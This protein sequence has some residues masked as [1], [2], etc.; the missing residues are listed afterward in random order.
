MY[1]TISTVSEEGFFGTVGGVVE[2]NCQGGR[3]V[4]IKLVLYSSLEQNIVVMVPGCHWRQKT[5]YANHQN[6]KMSIFILSS[7][8]PPGGPGSIQRV[9]GLPERTC[10]FQ[11]QFPGQ[12]TERER[13]FRYLTANAIWN[14][15]Y[16]SHCFRFTKGCAYIVGTSLKWVPN[17]VLP[18][19]P[20][21]V[22]AALPKSFH[23][24]CVH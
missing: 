3:R 24:S 15:I 21:R 1:S 13:A 19:S 12:Q 18:L 23:C 8:S 5:G 17:S 14:K 22:W 9:P 7:C 20:C 2:W 6:V 10:R 11:W 16:W 4:R